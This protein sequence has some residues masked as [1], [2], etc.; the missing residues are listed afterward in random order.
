M[1]KIDLR[2]KKKPK[3]SVI[4][5]FFNDYDTLEK[6][7]KSILNQSYKNFEL[8]IISDGSTDGSNKIAKKFL[9]KKNNILYL[10]SK[11]NKGLTKMLNIGITF[12]RGEYIARHDA[13]DISLPFRF[14]NQIDILKKRK[15]LDIIGSNAKYIY[16]NKRITT[17]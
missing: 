9:I 10:E 5:S 7:L 14:K 1:R 15:D 3:V 4:I 12:S 8:I 13:D 6:S 16:K 11:K 17:S 2:F